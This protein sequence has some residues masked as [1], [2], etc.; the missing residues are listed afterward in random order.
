MSGVS[1]EKQGGHCVVEVDGGRGKKEEMIGTGSQ[2][3]VGYSK[4]LGFY[5]NCDRMRSDQYIVYIHN[6]QFN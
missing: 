4:H 5:F 3:L 2:C 6:D 1:E